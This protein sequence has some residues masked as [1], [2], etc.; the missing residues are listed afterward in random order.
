MHFKHITE[1][2]AYERVVKATHRLRSVGF[3][4][5]FHSHP[6]IIELALDLDYCTTSGFGICGQG[7]YSGLI[8]VNGSEEY[9]VISIYIDTLSKEDT[10][11]QDIT[12]S[13]GEANP[14][15][16][17]CDIRKPISMTI[18]YHLEQFGNLP[19]RYEKDS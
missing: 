11:I 15:H 12:D 7:E 13:L 19:Q 17:K 1:N 16:K 8:V 9:R 5:L 6:K 10:L 18:L 14:E 4:E 2:Q 3:G